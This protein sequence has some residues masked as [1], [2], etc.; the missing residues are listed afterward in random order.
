MKLISI[1]VAMSVLLNFIVN[2]ECG[3]RSVECGVM[4]AECG[5]ILWK[6]VLIKAAFFVRRC[7]S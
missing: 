4:S 6:L 1:N 3:V 5:V 2:F 7:I